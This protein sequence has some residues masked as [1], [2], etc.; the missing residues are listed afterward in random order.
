[1]CPTASREIV[2]DQCGMQH[3]DS[4]IIRRVSHIQSAKNDG[5]SDSRPISNG[6]YWNIQEIVPTTAQLPAAIQ[7]NEDGYT[8]TRRK[9]S[10]RFRGADGKVW[11]AK[12]FLQCMMSLCDFLYMHLN[13]MFSICSHTYGLTLCIHMVYWFIFMYISK[14]IWKII[15]KPQFCCCRVHYE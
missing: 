8:T 13:L 12:H 15:N 7:E 9:Y 5:D 10:R 4:V 11:I 6:Y 3:S 1:M 2:I 14:T